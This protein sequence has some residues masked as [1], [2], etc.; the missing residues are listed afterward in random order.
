V[1]E[2]RLVPQARRS[3]AGENLIETHPGDKPWSAAQMVRYPSRRKF[4]QLLSDPS[5][6]PLEPYK[7]M[8]MELDLV[9]VSG[10]QQ[11]PDARW[12]VGAGLLALFLAVGWGRA[13]RKGGRT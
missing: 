1:A 9:A 6:G 8:S 2:E 5:Y 4:L 13:T 10:D 7:L 11:I 12:V 3:R